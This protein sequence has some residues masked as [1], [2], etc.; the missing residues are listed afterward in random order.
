MGQI[1]GEWLAAETKMKMLDLIDESARQGVS[2]RRSCGLMMIYRSRILRW[3][4]VRRNGGTLANDTPGPE[5]AL[6][7]L[8]PEER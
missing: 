5:Q 2:C 4:Q 8:L 1:T 3:Q 7:R 6:H